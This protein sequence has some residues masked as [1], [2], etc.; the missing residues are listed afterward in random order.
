MRKVDITEKLNFDENPILIIKGREIEVKSDAPTVLRV[1]GLMSS[2]TDIADMA[3][4]CEI[5]FTEKAN[6]TMKELNINISDLM[7]IVQEAIKLVV[8]ENEG[9]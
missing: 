4:A 1:M 7:I 9:K 3:Q 2:D 6:K 8:G 5:L